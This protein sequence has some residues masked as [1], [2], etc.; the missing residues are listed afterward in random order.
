MARSRGAQWFTKS[1][2]TT[3]WE[4][5][6]VMEYI[7]G[8]PTAEFADLLVRLREEGAEGCSPSLGLRDSLRATLIHM[9]HSIP[10]AVIGERLGVCR[11]TISRAVNAMTGAIV[12]ALKDVLLTAEEVPEVCDHVVDGALLPCWSW[13]N[14][15]ESWSW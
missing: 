8:P 15:R 12:W 10:Q 6:I 4:R 9:R 7:T 3:S 14:H 1:T 13:R 11:P 2:S 5:V